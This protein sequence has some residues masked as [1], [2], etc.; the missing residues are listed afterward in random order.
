VVDQAD[1]ADENVVSQL[2]LVGALV[3]RVV[4][5]QL[6]L[7][8][9]PQ[10]LCL[11]LREAPAE[12]IVL[13]VRSAVEQLVLAPLYVADRQQRQHQHTDDETEQ[14]VARRP[15]VAESSSAHRISMLRN[16]QIARL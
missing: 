4:D 11:E 7:V 12:R 9:Q 5:V 3:P 8:A 2:Q 16:C 15:R 13:V 10:L 14:V 1:A 6:Q